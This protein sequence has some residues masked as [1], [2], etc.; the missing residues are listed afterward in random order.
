MYITS[1]VVTLSGKIQHLT[2]NQFLHHSN[3]KCFRVWG[4]T[5]SKAAPSV[6]FATVSLKAA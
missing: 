6:F 4:H 1:V 5:Q 3:A 2:I